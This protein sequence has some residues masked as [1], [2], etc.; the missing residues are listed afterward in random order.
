MGLNIKNLEVERLATEVSMLTHETKTEAIR[1]ALLERKARLQSHG[2]LRNKKIPMSEYLKQ[3][4]WPLIPPG[5][6]G[7][8]L[9]REEEDNILGFG[10]DGF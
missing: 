7:R 8:T 6:Q 2:N 10:P 3:H 9:T 1:Q 5:Q 4:V